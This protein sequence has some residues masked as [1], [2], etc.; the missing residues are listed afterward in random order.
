[1][2]FSIIFGLFTFSLLRYINENTRYRYKM[3]WND[4]GIAVLTFFIGFTLD[5]YYF[6]TLIIQP[7]LQ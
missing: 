7:L 3:I 1:M 2:I 4:F 5:I 6:M